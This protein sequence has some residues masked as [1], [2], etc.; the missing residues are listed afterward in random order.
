MP[1]PPP[2]PY[3]TVFHLL[4][5]A[6]V[7]AMVP[8]WCAIHLAAAPSQRIYTLA[9]LIFLAILVALVSVNRFVAL[10]LVRQSPDLGRTE[11]LDWFLPYGWPSLMFAFESLGFGIFFSLACLLLIPVFR[12]GGLERTIAGTFA[13]IGVLS[14]GAAVGLALNSTDL[15]GLVAP[16]AWGIGPILA[17]VLV[18]RWL[19]FKQAAPVP[20]PA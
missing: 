8:L 16:V 13:V 10:T 1:F 15:M 19:R 6:S 3:S 2:E 12:T 4:L 7:L 20:V 5:L 17:A 9:S 11:G 18:V 14:P